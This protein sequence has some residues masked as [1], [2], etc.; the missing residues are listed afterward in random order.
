MGKMLFRM[1]G[2][3]IIAVFLSLSAC[4]PSDPYLD[5]VGIGV[6]NLKT[7]TDFY[8]DVVGMK[9]KYRMKTKS[10]EQVV[11]TFGG[12]KGSDVILMHYLDEREVNY[13]NNPDKLVFYVS[14]AA[15]LAQGISAAGLPIISAPT[16]MA[17]M[18]GVVV[19]M[20]KDPDGY[21]LEIVED[22]VTTTSY[23]GA[24]GIGVSDLE[25]S[26]DFYTRVMGMT[27]QYRL[28]LSF[29]NEIILEFE[30]GGGSAVVLMHYTAP[31]NYADL[32]VKLVYRMPDPKST[33]REIKDEGL[34]VLT[35]TK[36][37]PTAKDP[38]GY[39]LEILKA[40]DYMQKKSED[41]T[42]AAI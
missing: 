41:E 5:E 14:D 22:P 12:E 2:F 9:I 36:S 3:L 29:M 33:L 8:T 7:S 30:T 20:A 40:P 37:F 6:G 42:T 10:V 35:N 34:E 4:Q 26:A 18:G 1:S 31:K 13:T 23:L 19:G 15:K 16:A 38:D 28:S 25:A 21:L 24:I 27:E 17:E 32:P 11:L 39:L